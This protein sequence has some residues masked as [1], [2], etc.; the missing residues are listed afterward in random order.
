MSA[1]RVYAVVSSSR[2]HETSAFTESWL[3]LFPSMRFTCTGE[4]LRWTVVAQ[5]GSGNNN[6]RQ[7]LPIIWRAK[8]NSSTVFES[9][10][11][12]ETS[13]SEPMAV[14]NSKLYEF[15]PN[16][17]VVVEPGDMLGLHLMRPH[18][19]IQYEEESEVAAEY[20]YKEEE[21]S[22]ANVF[23]VNDLNVMAA[24]GVPLITVEIG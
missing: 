4:V 8:E 11:N 21:E 13:L 24:S 9:I 19:R 15:T 14:R 1:E 17:P 5:G 12:A 3:I 7:S 18:L 23:S 6:R 22:V 16:V 10:E 20:Y 2:I